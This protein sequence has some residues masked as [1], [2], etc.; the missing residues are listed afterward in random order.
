[1]YRKTAIRANLAATKT[2]IATAGEGSMCLGNKSYDSVSNK[3][4][5]RECGL[6]VSGFGLLDGWPRVR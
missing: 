2:G 5:R 4:V 6:L 1:M 3:T